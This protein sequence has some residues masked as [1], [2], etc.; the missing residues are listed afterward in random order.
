FNKKKEN[1]NQ[2]NGRTRAPAREAASSPAA[3]DPE[4]QK[5]LNDFQENIGAV[6]GMAQEILGQLAERHGVDGVRDAI[7]EAVIY[8][9][10]SL[11]YVRRVVEA[12]RR[13][14]RVI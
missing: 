5:L 7:R 1:R 6:T 8:E 2:E 4:L 12:W 3:A 9:K 11:A 10:R 13:N 14:G